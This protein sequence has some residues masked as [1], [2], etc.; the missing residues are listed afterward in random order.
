MVDDYNT[1]KRFDRD[2]RSLDDN[3]KKRVRI[4]QNKIV[5]SMIEGEFDPFDKVYKYSDSNEILFLDYT[6]NEEGEIVFTHIV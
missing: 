4:L 5:N 6:K 1:T 3:Q 2:F